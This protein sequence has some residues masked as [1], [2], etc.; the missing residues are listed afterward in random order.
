MDYE[1]IGKTILIKT[2]DQINRKNSSYKNQ[3]PA[4]EQTT[5]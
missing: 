4:C 2:F 5:S 3:I 1:W